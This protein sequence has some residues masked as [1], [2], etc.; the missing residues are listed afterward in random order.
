MISNNNVIP[1]FELTDE[2]LEDIKQIYRKMQTEL[3]SDYAQKYDLLINLVCD[4]LHYTFK[5]KPASKAEKQANASQRITHIFPELLELSV[6]VNHLNRAV[7]E[8][9]EKRHRR[10]LRN[11]YCRRQRFCEGIPNGMFP[12]LST[13]WSKEATHFNNFFRKNMQ[14]TPMR[15]REME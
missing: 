15:F 10:S 4:L 2:Q 9:T 5:M 8:I 14:M 1:V 12:K 6:H 13:H 3:V 11:V 7:K